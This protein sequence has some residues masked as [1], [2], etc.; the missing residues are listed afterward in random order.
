LRCDENHCGRVTRKF[1]Q[2]RGGKGIALKTSRLGA[3]GEVIYRDLEFHSS[4]PQSRPEV[5]T[6]M[7]L[8]VEI[9]FR[10]STLNASK[11]DVK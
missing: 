6:A 7:F 4:L 1:P 10:N 11:F 3:A 9:S 8:Q 2:S 5:R